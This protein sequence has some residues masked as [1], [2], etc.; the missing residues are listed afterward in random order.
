MDDDEAGSRVVDATYVINMDRSRDRMVDMAR[1]CEEHGLTFE[2]VPAVDGAALSRQQVAR[3]TTRLCGHFCTPAM[4]GCALSHMRVWDLVA[5]RGHA[6]TLVME[7]DAV[8]EPGFAAGVR[9]A[10]RDVPDNWDVLLLGCFMLC[11]KSRTYWGPHR[12]LRALLR[13]TGQGRTDTRAWGSVFVPEFFAGTHC[14]LVSQRGARK[15]RRLLTKANF[16]IDACMN[17]RRLNMYSVSPDLAYQRDMAASTIASFDFPK[18][19]VPLLARVRDP[20]RVSAAYYLSSPV[21]QVLGVRID[22]WALVFV[23]LGILYARTLPY[24]AGFL[25]AEVLVGGSMLHPL[26]AFGVGVS[27]RHGAGALVPRL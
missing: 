16:H 23:V 9:R 3:S 2:R 11:N 15:L 10:L 22:A 18:T 8:L 1:Q 19:L 25:C 14:Y 6:V 12:P 26:L 7:D 24:V 27:L 17:D 4:I 20:K 21:G 5:K 13:L